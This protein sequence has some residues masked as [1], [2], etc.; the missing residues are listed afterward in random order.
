MLQTR[1]TTQETG[2]RAILKSGFQRKKAKFIFAKK[3]SLIF[4]DY[5]FGIF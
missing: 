2:A 3:K 4:R 5:E 1:K